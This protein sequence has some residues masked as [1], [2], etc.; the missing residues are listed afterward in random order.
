MGT[1]PA[2]F[3]L[4][5]HVFANKRE[6]V[7]HLV[8]YLRKIPGEIFLPKKIG[9]VVSCPNNVSFKFKTNNFK[10]NTVKIYEKDIWNNCESYNKTISR[11]I[12]NEQTLFI[13]NDQPNYNKFWFNDS[14]L[15][16]HLIFFTIKGELKEPILSYAWQYWDRN[17]YLGT[18]IDNKVV[19]KAI[20]EYG[21]GGSGLNNFL[22]KMEQYDEDSPDG[23]NW[24]LNFMHKE[25]AISK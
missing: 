25:L 8:K 12:N 19:E 16:D 17:I 15:D 18:I 13:T 9:Y 20:E 6:N 11:I 3:M 1:R 24:D 14:T 4:I 2:P 22:R 7:T 5:S 10:C 23:F 21:T